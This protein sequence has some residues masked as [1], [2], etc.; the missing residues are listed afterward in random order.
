MRGTSTAGHYPNMSE[1]PQDRLVVLEQSNDKLCAVLLLAEREIAR[2]ESE[3]RESDLLMLIRDVRQ[4]AWAMRK[5]GVS[6]A[7]EAGGG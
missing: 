6:Q 4:E 1:L 7:A 2:Y 5:A 3:R